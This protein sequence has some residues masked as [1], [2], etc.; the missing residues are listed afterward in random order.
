MSEALR[1]RRGLA[2]IHIAEIVTD[3][4]E[5]FETGEIKRILAAAE[6]TTTVEQDKTVIWLDN[7]PVVTIGREGN[8]EITLNGSALFDA[9]QAELF[10]KEIDP[11]TG[12]IMDSGDFVEK[13]F[14]F[15]AE[16]GNHQS[17]PTLV[18]FLKT[19][20]SIPDEG[21]K[22]ED[23]STDWNGSELTL[24]AQK[25]IHEF[26]KTGKSC[27]RILLDPSTSELAEDADWFA[28]V[29]TPDNASTVM[30]KKAN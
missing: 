4:A 23:E 30:K 6:M 5:K 10:G 19:S 7:K 1:F 11:E 9:V 24:S 8:S 26:A 15:G 20:F 27:K 17:K 22:T 21:S 14:A 13:Y 29:V 28:Q 12:A 2:K 25:T 3:T 16:I 18:W